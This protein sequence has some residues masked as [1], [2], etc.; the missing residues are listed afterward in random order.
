MLIIFV[1]GHVIAHNSLPNVNF[2]VM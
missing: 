2:K 1:Q